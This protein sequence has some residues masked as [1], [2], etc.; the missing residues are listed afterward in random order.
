[1]NRVNKNDPARQAALPLSERLGALA[2]AS[3][4]SRP[5]AT[6]TYADV[7]PFDLPPRLSAI[8][9]HLQHRARVRQDAADKLRVG[10]FLT[11]T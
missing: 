2:A 5:P 6:S 11:G 8:L 3:A 10:E 1:M 7:P 4:A 9:G